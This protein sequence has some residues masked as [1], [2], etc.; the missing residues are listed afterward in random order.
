MLVMRVGRRC[1]SSPSLE[2][3]F[4]GGCGCLGAVRVLEMVLGQDTGEDREALAE[5]WPRVQGLGSVSHSR[6]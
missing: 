1:R 2:R 6:C 5:V 3:A 4:Q